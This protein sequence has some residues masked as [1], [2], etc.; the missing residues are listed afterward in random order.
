MAEIH[1]SKEGA[2]SRT[3][4]ASYGSVAMLCNLFQS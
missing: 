2:E 4:R 3:L 1:F